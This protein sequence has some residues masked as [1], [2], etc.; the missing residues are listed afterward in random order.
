M[1]DH[2]AP[3]GARRRP[4]SRSV[5][6]KGGARRAL[7]VDRS[8]AAVS[9]PMVADIPE[10]P[11]VV[12]PV[13][14]TPVE[15]LVRT[16]AGKRRAARTPQRSLRLLPSVPL[17]AGLA[18]LAVAALGATSGIDA[19]DTQAAAHRIRISA[20]GALS[21]SSATSS[22][23]LLSARGGGS[24]SRSSSRDA[25]ADTGD[26]ELLEQAEATA[27]QRDAALAQVAK[28]AESRAAT[29]A[30]NAWVVPLSTYHL[31]AGFGQASY[32]WSHLHTGQDLGAP[33]GTP[34]HNVA[35]GVV[36]ETGYDGSYGNK[37]VVTLDDG[38]EIWY[39]HQTSILVSVGD[40]VTGNEVIGLV[41]STG[42]STGPHLHIEVRPGGGDPVDPVPAFLQHGVTL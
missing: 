18:T 10:T 29:I 15:P 24:V 39:C 17:V 26:T 28:K 16:A 14:A 34:I 2:R 3:R 25:V 32:L 11:T 21:G 22:S 23:D 38:T 7:P 41:G 13:L 5:A 8:P 27:E 9:A 20:A 33:I 40:R 4:L 6:P 35:N 31:S 19:A 30:K 1:G 36:T 37:T 42:N 12:M